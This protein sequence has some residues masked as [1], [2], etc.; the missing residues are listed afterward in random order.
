MNARSNSRF[1]R[2]AIAASLAVHLIVAAIVHSHPVT[3]APEQK[4]KTTYI[5][6]LPPPTPTPPPPTPQPRHPRT[7]TASRPAIKVVKLPQHTKPQG[8]PQVVPSTQPTGNTGD[9]GETPGP[10]PSDVG[11][12]TAPIVPTPTPKPACSAPDIP[13]RT[14]VTQAVDKPDDADGY[15]GEAKV[16]VDLDASGD[17]LGASIYESTGSMQLDRAAVAAARASRYAPEERDC[18]NVPGS[19]LFIVDFE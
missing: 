15:S 17:V 13:A 2:I 5:V 19:Y 7:T 14:L 10:G 1:L 16:K 18:K 4:P 6:Q 3:A 11:A 8:P 9:F 12:T